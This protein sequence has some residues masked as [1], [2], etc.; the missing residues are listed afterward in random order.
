MNDNKVIATVFVLV[1]LAIS[2]Q[3]ILWIDLDLVFNRKLNNHRQSH[4]PDQGN[5]DIQSSKIKKSEFKYSANWNSS[6]K[7]IFH[8]KYD[9]SDNQLWILKIK[10]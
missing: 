7:I 1:T 5:Y 10:N 9:K 8:L 3:L 6:V 4:N 2:I